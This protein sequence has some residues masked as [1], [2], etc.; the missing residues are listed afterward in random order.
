MRKWKSFSFNE[1]LAKEGERPSVC[2]TQHVE[3]KMQDETSLL[4]ATVPISMH[5]ESP[6]Y[7]Y[8]IFLFN[9]LDF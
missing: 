4:N 1:N 7:Q 6:K 2:S 9:T 5:I 8:K 3:N